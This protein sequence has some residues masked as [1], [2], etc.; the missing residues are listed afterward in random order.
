MVESGLAENVDFSGAED[1][2]RY[3]EADITARNVAGK[4]LEDEELAREM[5]GSG[6]GTPATRAAIIERL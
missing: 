5:K 4:D 1:G 6:I 3:L 2:I